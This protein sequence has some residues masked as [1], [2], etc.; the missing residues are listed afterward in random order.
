M[1]ATL[2]Y[3]LKNAP[4]ELFDHGRWTLLTYFILHANIRNRCWPSM[5]YLRDRLDKS[6]P[7]LTQA[8]QWLLDHGA[9]R[10]VTTD[11]R[12][13]DERDQPGNLHI[14]ELTGSIKF[15]D[16]TV[17]YLYTSSENG[18]TGEDVKQSETSLADPLL[19]NVYVNN[20]SLQ[21]IPNKD[22]SNLNTED[23]PP[24]AN[25]PA[26]APKAEPVKPADPIS[27][28]GENADLKTEAPVIGKESEKS[29]PGVAEPPK[30][31]PVVNPDMPRLRH[32]DKV[33]A[34][35][36]PA[37][38][39]WDSDEYVYIGRANKAY[40]LP[41][42]KWANP[43]PMKNESEREEVVNR[44]Y[45]HLTT[46][47][48]LLEALPE[49]K[50]KIL[51]CWCAPKECHGDHLQR[52]VM[53][54]EFTSQWAEQ[55]RLTPDPSPILER[56]INPDA[57][58]IALSDYVVGPAPSYAA[59]QR[60]TEAH[61]GTIIQGQIIGARRIEG[62]PKADAANKAAKPEPTPKAD[63]PH[64]AQA[65]APVFDEMV[66]GLSKAKKITPEARGVW[67]GRVGQILHGDKRDPDC[68]GLIAYECIRQGK[69][70]NELDY[71]ALARQVKLFWD[72]FRKN[73]PDIDLAGC[74]KVLEWW[75]KFRVA[76][77][78]IT[79]ATFA[80]P[81]AD[82]P[83]CRGSGLVYWITIEGQA[84]RR[85]VQGENLFGVKHQQ[86]TNPCTCVKAVA[87]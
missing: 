82:C 3:Q 76:Q 58:Y 37:T 35:W 8:K 63:K 24:V 59:A 18:D 68:T 2:N 49:L 78:K 61:G 34:H 13:G 46:N 23:S 38:G 70:I 20:L 25:A 79:P 40:G 15:A 5:R 74:Q 7:H 73:H 87:S 36:N 30:L 47:A 42:S 41:Q 66:V 26:D 48:D 81:S 77:D 29:P 80:K 57:H 39:Q 45:H 27:T 32:F 69:A 4:S 19:N 72:S 11:E 22:S 44:Y 10:L 43:F 84:A 83:D 51:V 65:S 54:P 1:V 50:G 64:M 17:P 55:I 85:K 71:A 33:K 9:I 14:Y 12:V 56:A 16:K 6:L 53:R 60:Y 75:D 28:A 67:G 31:N 62:W 86:Y 52:L 21:S